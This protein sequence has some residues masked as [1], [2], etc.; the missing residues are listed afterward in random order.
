MNKYAD[1]YEEMLRGALPEYEGKIAHLEKSATTFYPSD[2]MGFHTAMAVSAMKKAP[3]LG[4]YLDRIHTKK[5]T[6][7]DEKN[8]AYICEAMERFLPEYCM[9][10]Q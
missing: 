9:K 1:D 2:Q 10:K 5:D 3:V 7:M 6:A 8:I 4:L